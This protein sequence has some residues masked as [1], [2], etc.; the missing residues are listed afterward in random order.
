MPNRIGRLGRFTVLKHNIDYLHAL[1]SI[2]TVE[3]LNFFLIMNNNHISFFLFFFHLN[4]HKNVLIQ[5]YK[6]LFQINQTRPSLNKLQNI[7]PYHHYY[8]QTASLV[9]WWT[10][11]NR[12]RVLF[13]PLPHSC[14]MSIPIGS[15]CYIAHT[16]NHGSFDSNIV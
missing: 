14:S 12:I 4:Y 3:V 16:G 1:Q 10:L 7:E 5:Q 15:V 8:F 11:P 13:T 9:T 2:Y 6:T